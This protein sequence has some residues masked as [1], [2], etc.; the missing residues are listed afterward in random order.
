VTDGRYK[1]IRGYDPSRA[2]RPGMA[3]TP[4]PQGGKDPKPIL[5]DL[6]AD[7]LENHDIADQRPEV[8]ARLAKLLPPPNTDPRFTD[9]RSQRF[10]GGEG[11]KGTGK[12]R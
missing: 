9:Q 5:F 1:L 3:A 2:F 10:G 4:R 7:P 11:R 8:V 12:K 6:G